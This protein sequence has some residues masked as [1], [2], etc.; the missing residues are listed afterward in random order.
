MIKLSSALKDLVQGNHFLEFGFGEGLLNNSA[1]AEWLKPLL[2]ARTKKSI[3]RT[4]I[5]MAL[6][7]LSAVKRKIKPRLNSYKL[8]SVNIKSRLTELTF[9]NVESNRRI[10]ID[11]MSRQKDF[12]THITSAFGT[13]EITIILPSTMVAEVKSQIAD[14]PIFEKSGLAALCVTFPAQYVLEPYILYYLIQQVTLQNINIWEISST[15]TEIIFYLD[16]KD[17]KL[18]FET[19]YTQFVR[20]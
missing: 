5:I 10:I 11:L 12:S 20:S 19:I 14:P 1:T 7:R 3:S 18:A 2:E 13:K 8:D 6:S 9:S 17:V 15:Y 16:E 4:S